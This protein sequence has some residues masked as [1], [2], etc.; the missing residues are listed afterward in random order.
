[1]L[2][3]LDIVE[4]IPLDSINSTTFEIILKF[5]TAH[6]DD[7][8]PERPVEKSIE[9]LTPEDIRLLDLKNELLF[10]VMVSPLTLIY[11][12]RF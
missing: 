7:E 1:M 4:T 8:I 6:K 9:D 3:D 10:D 5:A 12:D 2:Q 11:V